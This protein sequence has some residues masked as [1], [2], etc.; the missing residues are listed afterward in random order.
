MDIKE[1]FKS[2]TASGSLIAIICAYLIM[3]F[4]SNSNTF[5]GLF[6][7]I[8]YFLSLVLGILSLN[9]N[10]KNILGQLALCIALIPILFLL[11]AIILIE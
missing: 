5:N 7:I 2:K 6:S 1:N 9:F 11:F 10:K 4:G 3:L 8:L